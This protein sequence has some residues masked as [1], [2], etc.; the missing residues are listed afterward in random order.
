MPDVVTLPDLQ[1]ELYFHATINQSP[2]VARHCIAARIKQRATE[3]VV[4]VE[5]FVSLKHKEMFVLEMRRSIYIYFI[6]KLN[7]SGWQQRPL[8]TV[9]ISNRQNKPALQFLF[10]IKCIVSILIYH[11][12]QHKF[13]KL[14]FY[15]EF[16]VSPSP[17]YF[18]SLHTFITSATALQ[19]G[20]AYL[21]YLSLQ[22]KK[23]FV[24]LVL[25]SWIL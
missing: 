14:Q 4:H 15:V 12:I 11:S 6:Y 1:L 24:Y 9:T 19:N 21:S 10:A 8:T 22:P 25:N 2:L 20:I 17:V 23:K 13:K 3:R 5:A 7:I 16:H 18:F